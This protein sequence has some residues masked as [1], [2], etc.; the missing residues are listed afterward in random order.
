MQSAINSNVRKSEVI[1]SLNV[2]LV[3]SDRNVLAYLAQFENEETQCEKALEALKVGVIALQSASPTLDTTVVQTHFAEMESSM[4]EYVAMFQKSIKDDLKKYFESS[5]GV[6]PRSIADI[7]GEGGTL[8]RTFRAFFDPEDGRLGRLMQTHV[9]PESTFG[10]SLDPQNKQ[11]VIAIL[12]ARVQELVEAKLDDVLKEFSLDQNGSAMSRLHGMLAESFERINRALGHNDGQKQEAKKGHVKG[13]R[14]EQELYDDYFVSLCT[15]C[16]DYPSLVARTPGHIDGCKTGDLMSTLGEATG[17]PGINIVIEVKD[18]E[19]KLTDARTELQEAKV[20]RKAAIG[21]YVWSR[22]TEPSEVGD[23]RRIGD[24]FY[25][26]AD[27]EDLRAGKPL[28]Y[29]DV[30]YRIA[31]AMA[32]AAMRRESANEIDLGKIENHVEALGTWSERVAD[33]SVKARTIQKSGKLIEECA[34]DLKE[35]L[36]RRVAEVLAT[37]RHA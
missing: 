34:V 16:D 23:F 28:L 6:V 22:G 17:T 4:Q 9:G 10:K 12:E 27:M 2:N 33:M 25:V 7:F 31:R 11:G 37:L 19:V 24:D 14:F 3:I 8:S 32:V 29:F 20:N 13:I 26:T 1:S 15:Q 5:D 36:D 18:R 30:A 21:I 35:E